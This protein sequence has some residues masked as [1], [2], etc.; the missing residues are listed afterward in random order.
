MYYKE[1]HFHFQLL[2][3]I[4]SNVYKKNKYK[5]SQTFLVAS[6]SVRNNISHV[7]YTIYSIQ[8][9]DIFTVEKAENF[10]SLDRFVHL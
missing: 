3:N 4:M 10:A 9:G 1:K 8:N 5:K 7:N 2:T 6:H